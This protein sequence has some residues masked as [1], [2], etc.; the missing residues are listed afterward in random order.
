MQQ[1]TSSDYINVKRFY[2][3]HGM[4]EAYIF[5]S[6]AV[7]VSI[8]YL[9]ELSEK[10]ACSKITVMNLIGRSLVTI[11]IEPDVLCLVVLEGYS[12]FHQ[13]LPHKVGPN[14]S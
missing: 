10:S 4:D 2:L 6:C 7:N 11:E 5:Y 14:K 9:R 3:F 8:H 12:P 13:S 1:F